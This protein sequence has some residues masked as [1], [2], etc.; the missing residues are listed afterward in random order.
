MLAG[1]RPGGDPLARACGAPS[2]ALIR[3]DGRTMLG[4]VVHALL[5]SRDIG[6]VVI[7]AQ[8]AE[9]IWESE[10]AWA[11]CD[12]RVHF[13]RSGDGIA[14]SIAA[15][16]G[17][18][19]APWPVLVTTA[20]NALLTHDRVE[21]FLNAADE[22]DITIGVGERTIV[23]AVY[24][25]T[26]RTWLKFRDGQ[27]SGANLFALMGPAC[28]AALEHWSAVEQDRKKGLKLVASFGPWILLQVL[29]HRLTFEQ[30]LTRAGK[31]LGCTAKYVILDA[32][33]PIDVD[34]A[35]D[36]LLVQRILRDRL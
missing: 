36:Y 28:N 19:S 7:L 2:K 5:A 9:M 29:L 22:T 35:D 23:E 32:E 26:K 6:R 13:V 24:P 8:Q 11:G 3:I 30:A 12:E 10:A 18:E 15:L 25:Q 14:G 16:A 4:I 20:D 21:A 1:E 34:K 33:A 27:F 17:T 31:A